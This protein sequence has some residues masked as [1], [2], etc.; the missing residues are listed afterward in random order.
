M[1]T[2]GVRAVRSAVSPRLP[3][4]A[5]LTLLL[6][7]P[8]VTFGTAL[9]GSSGRAAPHPSGPAAASP[10]RPADPV[11]PSAAGSGGWTNRTSSLSSA[12]P[13]RWGAMSAYD[14]ADGYLL[15]FGGT[16]PTHAPLRD[17]WTYSGGTWRN[18]TA[19]AGTAPSARSEGTM[20]YDPSANEVVLYGGIHSGTY[21]GD[22]WTFSAGRWSSLA[23]NTTPGLLADASMA[24]DPL[25]GALI[26]FGGSPHPGT[27]DR[28]AT[29]AF[30]GGVW[31][32]LTAS[33]GTSP[34]ARARAS[35]TYD[36]Q[37]GEIVLFG[38]AGPRASY[39]DTWSFS[40]GKWVDRTADSGNAP[41]ARQSAGFD[42]D[43]IDG[44]DVLFGGYRGNVSFSDTWEYNG[45]WSMLSAGPSPSARNM[46]MLAYTPG[47]SA[48]NASILL[49]GGR[50]QVAN[51][52]NGLGDTWTY[53]L[54][55]QA[56]VTLAPPRVDLHQTLTVGIHVAGGVSPYTV[57]WS[58]LPGGCAGA[59]MPIS[60]FCTPQLIGSTEVQAVVTDALGAQMNATPANLSVDSLPVVTISAENTTGPAPLAVQFQVA[61]LGGTAPFSYAWD[62]GN[63]NSSTVGP[64]NRTYTA[65]GEYT[66]ELSVTDADGALASSAPISVNVTA[67]L[68]VTAVATALYGSAPLKVAF[69]STV[70]GGEAPYT[71]LWDLGPGA[72]LG[73]LAFDSTTF[74]TP[75][76]YPVRL[77][78]DDHR[79]DAAIAFLN[80]TVVDPLQA[81]FTASFPDNPVC[82]GSAV[83]DFLQFTAQPTGGTPP[84]NESWV[85]NGTEEYGATPSG[86]FLGTATI[87][88]TLTIT[89]SR[90]NT[91]SQ[92]QDILIPTT[93][94]GTVSAS[95]RGVSGSSLE[96]YEIGAGLLSLIIL[97]ELVVLV[98]RH[99]P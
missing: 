37:L 55:L 47:P 4:L 5:L 41:S 44:Y 51:T 35:M 48:A 49:F 64:T 80:I 15:L 71:Y 1:S 56:F 62:F 98:R 31:A 18:I 86:S 73:T 7:L 76:T 40:G 24:Y 78:V 90:N 19:T 30:T 87:P 75:G 59:S 52:A 60:F 97:V 88:V 28:N 20:A 50:S 32:N 93:T 39:N 27:V 33:A 66:A 54:P 36:A 67:A 3:W 94:C 69:S 61:I 84:Y 11:H 13:G 91:S 95:T 70:S 38:G 2:V 96:Y 92:E 74:T 45:T 58:G 10:I 79:G 42:N 23:G 65:Q 85:I 17:T 46:E 25:M 43:A 89:D 14:A 82:E 72:G 8:G 77:T 9:P 99:R 63:G 12:P 6:V 81:I 53:K 26:L 68:T 22:T 21:L 83:H 16:G 57:N 29:Y 34:P